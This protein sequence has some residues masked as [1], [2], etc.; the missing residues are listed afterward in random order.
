MSKTLF[1]MTRFWYEVLKFGY[2]YSFGDM[3]ISYAKYYKLESKMDLTTR[4]PLQNEDTWIVEACF[5]KSSQ[6]Q[7]AVNSYSLFSLAKQLS[8]VV[9]LEP[10]DHTILQSKLVYRD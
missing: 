3:K 9:E 6:D 1:L 10:V 4:I 2:E 8:T 5:P 7:L